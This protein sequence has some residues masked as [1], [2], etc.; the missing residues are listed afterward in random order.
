MKRYCQ[1]E[2]EPEDEN[3]PEAKVCYETLSAYF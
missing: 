3:E 1:N 2:N